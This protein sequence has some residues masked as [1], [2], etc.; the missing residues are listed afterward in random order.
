MRIASGESA[1][2][3]ERSTPTFNDLSRCAASHANRSLSAPLPGAIHQPLVA[4]PRRQLKREHRWEGLFACACGGTFS[5]PGEASPSAAIAA[6]LAADGAVA[7]A[8]CEA[9][10][11]PVGGAE[12]ITSVPSSRSRSACSSSSGRLVPPISACAWSSSAPCS[13]SSGCGTAA[14]GSPST[15]PSPPSSPTGGS[16]ILSSPA[17][18]SSSSSSSASASSSPS[19]SSASTTAASIP[20]CSSS[21]SGPQAAS[22]PSA[23][24]PSSGASSSEAPSPSSLQ[25]S[26]RLRSFSSSSLSEDK[27]ID[28]RSRSTSR[29]PLRAERGHSLPPHGVANLLSSPSS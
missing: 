9:G 15:R 28:S 19:S 13:S 8:A 5:P 11:L 25:S 10:R 2:Y 27:P 7:G 18:F 24:S 29:W 23:A 16:A 21:M 17:S 20:A 14:G 26:C 3:E 6:T 22:P 4:E 12:A 1:H